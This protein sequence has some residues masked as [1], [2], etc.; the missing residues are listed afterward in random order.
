MRRLKI[1][2]LPGPLSHL[3]TFIL[4]N[5][6]MTTQKI[7]IMPDVCSS[8]LWESKA[9]VM[10]EY[11]DITTTPELIKEI[12]AWI[13]FYDREC[14]T[15]PDYD[16][17]SEKALELNDRGLEIAKKV[18]QLNPDSIVGYVGES[19]NCIFDEELV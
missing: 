11:E 12:K 2:I 8:G 10:L 13:E 17:V 7:T 18:K 6:K 16:F 1:R 15:R 9:G 5:E 3:V 14:L 4:S 19:K